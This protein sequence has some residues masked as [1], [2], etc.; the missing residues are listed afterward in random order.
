MKIIHTGA[1]CLLLASCGQDG[2]DALPAKAGPAAAAAEATAPEGGSSAR[3]TFRDWKAVCDNGKRCMTYS[4]MGTGGWLAIRLDA[5]PDARPEILM[6]LSAISGVP[7][8]LVI[9][10]RAQT[11]TAP[12]EGE[13]GFRVPAADVSAT[14]ARLAAATEIKLAAPEFE[15]E[16]P[17]AGASAALL[18]I[19]EQQGRLGT[20]TALIRKGDRPASTVPAAPSLPVVV[21]APAVSQTG[22]GDG[23]QTLPAELEALPAVKA[24]RAETSF[25]ADISKA[26][27]SARL[28]ASTELWAVPCFSGAY[29]MGHDWYV[30]GPGGRDPRGAAL[31]VGDSETPNGTVNGGYDPDTRTIEAFSKGRGLGDCGIASTWTWTGR[32]FVLTR[33]ATMEDCEGIPSDVWPTTRR[34]R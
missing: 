30:T 32:A 10:G 25:N 1:A 34:T 26:V 7:I 13:A 6:D 9:D 18:W 19:D 20:T 21:A 22:F 14:L 11:L 2:A 12:T 3:R 23:G 16:I 29:N 31:T 33:E 24:C 5:G 17:A 8:R 15:G 28:D 27:M 4:G